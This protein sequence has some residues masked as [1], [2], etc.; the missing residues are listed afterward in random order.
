MAAVNFRPAFAELAD[1]IINHQ[2]RAEDAMTQIQ[3]QMTQSAHAAASCPDQVDRGA[4]PGLLEE[5][6]DLFGSQRAHRMADCPALAAPIEER[7]RDWLSL[8]SDRQCPVAFKR[9]TILSAI[10]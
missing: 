10:C 9:P 6:T 5:L 4:R 7:T 8:L 3:Q 2:V 1:F